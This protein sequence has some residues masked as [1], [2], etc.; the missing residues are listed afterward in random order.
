MKKLVLVPIVVVYIAVFMF[1]TAAMDSADSFEDYE[2]NILEELSDIIDD[3]TLEVLGYIGFE[4]FSF[5]EIYN[6]SFEKISSFFSITLK[7]KVTSVVKDFFEIL[8]VVM[9]TGVV[10]TVYK[11]NS[12]DSFLTVIC[13]LTVTLL[14]VTSVNDS[15]NA[16]VS[17]LQAS[18]KFMIGFV[19]IYTLLISFS[20]NTATALTYNTFAMFFAEVIS[21]IISIGAVD[22]IGIYFSLGISFSLNEGINV[23]RFNSIVNKTV[24]IVLGFVSSAFTGFLSLKSILSVS[25]D[26]VSLRSVRYLIGSLIPVVGSSISE[27]YSS[28]L[29]S[30]NLIKSSVAIV[31]ILVITIINTPIILEMLFYFVALNMLGY[32]ADSML[33]GRTGDILRVFSGGIRLLLLLCIFEMFIMIVTIGIVL[34]AKNGG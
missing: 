21:S 24:N 33:L 15:I 6:I 5:D 31:G 20:G 12:D 13:T 23:A 19:P 32:I 34:S 2:N 9:L 29:G 18:G 4:D 11:S 10:S 27:A 22:L 7:D 14:V 26:R 1:N 3:E 28:L 16:F 25:V 17:T 30:I 8:C